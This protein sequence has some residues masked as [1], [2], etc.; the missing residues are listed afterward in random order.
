MCVHS[1][2]EL[3]KS[4]ASEQPRPMERVYPGTTLFLLDRFGAPELSCRCVVP[5]STGQ[6]MMSY[7]VWWCMC[8]SHGLAGLENV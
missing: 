7:C 4:R 3:G 2:A 8:P 1:I 6:G 5:S